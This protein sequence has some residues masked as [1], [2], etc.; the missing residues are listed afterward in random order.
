MGLGVLDVKNEH[1]P[2]ELVHR[3]SCVELALIAMR[4]FRDLQYL[5]TGR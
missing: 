3:L 1:V 2:G 4:Y 5:R